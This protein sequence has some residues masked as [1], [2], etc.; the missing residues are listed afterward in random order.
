M[1]KT[2]ARSPLAMLTGSA[3]RE[4]EKLKEALANAATE[5]EANAFED[6]VN[7]GEEKISTHQETSRNLARFAD[8]APVD[9]E[10]RLEEKIS[11]HG[12]AEPPLQYLHSRRHRAI[13][14]RPGVRGEAQADSRNSKP[15][16]RAQAI[17]SLH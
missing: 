11:G 12:R 10:I 4:L 1:A 7:T 9:Q 6:R 2:I 16:R 5:A 13:P 3:T 17:Q 15:A 8:A 14:S